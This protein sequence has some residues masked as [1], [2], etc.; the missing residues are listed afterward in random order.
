[1]TE[2]VFEFATAARIIFGAG[3]VESIGNLA[4]KFGKRAL[5][6][7]GRDITRA[8]PVW[9][10]LSRAQVEG[11]A[12]VVP[13]EPST[14][15]VAE[16]AEQARE[17]GCDLVIGCGGG[18][19]IDA[20]KAIS[21]LMTNG[22]EPLDYL[23]VIGLGKPITQRA[24]PCIAVPTTAG[25]GTEVTRNAVLV[26]PEHRVKVSLR[27]PLILPEIALVDPQLTYSMPPEI[28]ASTGLDA[29]TQ[30]I[31][32]YVSRFANPLTDAVCREGMASAS[33][34]LLLAYANGRDARAR[35]AMAL[36]SLCGGLALA[37]AKLG[38]V[39]GFAGV[40]GGMFDAP[41]GAICGRLLPFVMDANVQ[42]LARDPDSQPA[43]QRFT[44][45]ARI[46]TGNAKAAAQEGVL[47]IQELVESLHVPGLQ[48]YGV[49]PEDFA[50]IIEKA[51]HSSSMRGNPIQLSPEVLSDILYQ[52]L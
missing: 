48:N 40:L 44:E 13:R 29:L 7:T 52:A 18:S 31:E 23:E 14:D 24:A 26:S 42:A 2:M 16:G 28:T 30:L 34:A 15:L 51:V 6:V 47:W 4:Q 45:I 11:M 43:Y 35:E 21:A 8:Q 5:V 39:H 32:P 37:N 36:A 46:I 41:H 3:S 10:A 33:S 25:T 22:G 17:A 50:D 9:D 1:M 19:V 12:F 27:S 38:A 20:A 49:G